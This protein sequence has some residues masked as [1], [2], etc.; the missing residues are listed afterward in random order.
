MPKINIAIDGTSG[1]GKSSVADA[2]AAR[3]N[4]RHLDTG[5]MY[6]TVAL[7]LKR[8]GI[9]LQDEQALNDALNQISISFDENNQVHLNGENVSKE[10][11]TN[12]I[13]NYSSKVASLKP[14]RV[15]LVELQQEISAQKGYI[16]DGRDI[17]SVVLPH[18]ELKLFMSASPQARAQRRFKEYQDQGIDADY[19]TIYQDIVQ[20]DYQDSHR[21]I[22]PLVKA[23]DAIE[24]DTSDLNLEQVVDKI[25]QLIDQTLQK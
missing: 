8:A 17:C 6:R 9:D 15:R 4:M 2:L 20:R 5:A 14:V 19:E 11:R 1:V 10:I 23:E 24:I 7:A 21:A 25:S 16:V 13:S 3:Y 22:S 12:E 18:A